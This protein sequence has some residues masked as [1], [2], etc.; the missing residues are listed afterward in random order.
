MKKHRVTFT[1]T[2]DA[3]RHHLDKIIGEGLSYC[4]NVAEVLDYEWMLH[5][6]AI[7]EEDN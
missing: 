5:D 2:T 7:E 4:D 6:Y 3:V 1:V